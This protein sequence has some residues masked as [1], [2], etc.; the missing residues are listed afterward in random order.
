MKNSARYGIT[1]GALVLAAFLLGRMAES[2]EAAVMVG[3]FVPPFFG[4]IAGYVAHAGE[5][6]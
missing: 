3:L 6:S 2:Q 1:T 4:A 5:G